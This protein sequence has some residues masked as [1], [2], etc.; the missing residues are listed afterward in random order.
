MGAF[1]QPQ[2]MLIFPSR[3]QPGNEL[4]GLH[5]ASSLL[6]QINTQSCLKSSYKVVV[7]E[8]VQRKRSGQ[9]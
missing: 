4:N 2:L 1:Q 5:E 3:I 7:K 8:Y 9:C 6:E